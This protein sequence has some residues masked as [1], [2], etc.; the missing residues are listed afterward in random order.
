MGETAMETLLPQWP[1]SRK[2][3]IGMIHLRAL[4]G[5]PGYAGNLDELREAA[6]RD[7]DALATGGVDGLM[8]E[9]FGD[10]PF[11]PTRVPACV[12]AQMTAIA[13]EVKGRFPLPLGINVL[14]NDGLGALAVA[15]A[16]GAEFIRVNVLCGARVADQGILQGIAHDLL[17]ERSLMQAT[18]KILADVDVKHSAPLAPRELADEVDDTIRRGLADAVIVSGA[19]TG[20]TTT[21]EKVAAVKSFAG[22][23]PVFVGSGVSAGT[24]ASYPSADGFIVGTAFKK[25]GN[26]ANPVEADR[27]KMLRKALG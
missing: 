20:K 6:M 8:I 9:N 27:V 14:R 19:G 5:A 12:V 23:V 1:R 11:Y 17:R 26:P 21:P 22:N 15:H 7:A 2:I 25:D 13:A 10:V 4:P 18:V 24:V 16:V 3:V